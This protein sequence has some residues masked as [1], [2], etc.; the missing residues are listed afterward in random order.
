MLSVRTVGCVVCMDRNMLMLFE[1][2]S[3]QTAGSYQIYFCGLIYCSFAT[4]GILKSI[5][6]QTLA[7][8]S[9]YIL[10]QSHNGKTMLHNIKTLWEEL[11]Y[12][13]KRHAKVVMHKLMVNKH[14]NVCVGF[15]WNDVRVLLC[16]LLQCYSRSE[17]YCDTWMH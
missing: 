8:C 9:G 3:L 2:N 6:Q 7:V 16:S 1:Q 4:C 10:E 14:K 17:G 13:N 11:G 12:E 5:P 15:Y